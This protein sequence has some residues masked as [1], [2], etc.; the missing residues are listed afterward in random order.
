[1]Q[2]GDIITK[3]KFLFLPLKINGITKFFTKETY[4]YRCEWNIHNYQ[5]TFK[6]LN[7]GESLKNYNFEKELVITFLN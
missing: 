7:W 5:P 2:H 6:Y 4:T 1:M 3:T